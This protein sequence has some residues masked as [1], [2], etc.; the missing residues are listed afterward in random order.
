MSITENKCNNEGNNLHHGYNNLDYNSILSKKSQTNDEILFPFVLSLP[1]SIY[2]RLNSRQIRTSS[3][4][5]YH[6]NFI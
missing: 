1:Y 4:R 5:T 3:Q 6:P 2:C